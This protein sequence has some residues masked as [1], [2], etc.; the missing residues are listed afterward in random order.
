MYEYI[1]LGTGL[2][3]LAVLCLPIPQLQRLLLDVSAWALRLGLLAVLAGG[4]Y[5]W[6]RPGEMPARVTR[7]LNDF[8]GLLALLPEPDSPAF[9]PGLAFAVVAP[10]VP[11][12]A[13]LDVT[14]GLTRRAARTP[15]PAASRTAPDRT[16]GPLPPT[17]ETMPVGVPLLRPV[18]RRT[19]AAAMAAAG[20]DP[21]T[22]A[23]R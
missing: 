7:A 14:R 3:A 17:E 1:L 16:V 13:I 22:R 20:S 18:E 2:G 6:C 23:A 21:A 12:L 8:P 5:L 15:A 11:L 9:A 19:A 4:A 10:L